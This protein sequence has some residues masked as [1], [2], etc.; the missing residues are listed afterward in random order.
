MR[1]DQQALPGMDLDIAWHHEQLEEAHEICDK[2]GQQNEFLRAELAKHG[3][4]VQ[5]NEEGSF[6]LGGVPEQQQ[7][8]ASFSDTASVTP[9]G[10]EGKTAASDM[11]D[12]TAGMR[13]ALLN[14]VRESDAACHEL[15]QM[16]DRLQGQLSASTSKWPPSISPFAKVAAGTKEEQMQATKIL[17]SEAGLQAVEVRSHLATLMEILQ[18]GGDVPADR[19]SF[20]ST[21]EQHHKARPQSA[22][23]RLSFDASASNASFG[24]PAARDSLESTGTVPSLDLQPKVKQSVSFQMLDQPAYSAN[25]DSFLPG[26]KKL[27]HELSGFD[28]D[29]DTSQLD[30]PLFGSTMG[31]EHAQ[32]M[33]GVSANRASVAAQMF[34]NM[35]QADHGLIDESQQQLAQAVQDVRQQ[36]RLSHSAVQVTLGQT[37]RSC[38]MP[39]KP[40]L[41]PH[42][43]V[44]TSTLTP[45]MML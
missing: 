40:C 25:L 30:N 33:L 29:Y 1:H 20:E 41:V 24:E 6:A 17:C 7:H 10:T 35:A 32:G 2:L 22:A 23:W 36:V 4:I 14:M 34:K 18:Q 16:I 12:S 15:Q 45:S 11:G 37:A 42:K 9:S 5:G 3:V 44:T 43:Y 28:N 39:H 19:N 38:L 8:S 27:D 31:R 26:S 21:T 13:P